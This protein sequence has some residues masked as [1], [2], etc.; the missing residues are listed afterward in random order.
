M[1][2]QPTSAK[3]AWATMVPIKRIIAARN[4][5]ASS[6]APDRLNFIQ[7]HDLHNISLREQRKISHE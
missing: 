1:A 7:F 4:H 6:E 2:E 3:P 5:P